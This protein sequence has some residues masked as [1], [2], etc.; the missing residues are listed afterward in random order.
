MAAATAA[1]LGLE[2]GV[3]V[4]VKQGDG[5]AELM[6]QVDASVAEGCVCVAA[7]H[8]ATSMLGALDGAL[9]VERA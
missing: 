9:S 2:D 3:A 6:L 8:P 7:G 4:K 5:V 1:R